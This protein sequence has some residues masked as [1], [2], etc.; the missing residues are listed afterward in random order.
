[1]RRTRRKARALHP[2]RERPEHRRQRE[3]FFASLSDRSAKAQPVLL[4]LGPAVCLPVF[5][6][7]PALL[8]GAPNP[9]QIKVRMASERDRWSGS[10]LRHS[11]MSCCDSGWSRRLITGFGPT[12]GR[13]R[14]F[15]ITIFES[16]MRRVY[17]KTRTPRIQGNCRLRTPAACPPSPWECQLGRFC[18]RIKAMRPRANRPP[19]HWRKGVRTY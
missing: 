14:F 13:P 6:P 15:R 7:I 5:A 9:I 1:V 4:D 2:W 11:S 16:D 12:R 10:P 18:C 17:N 19:Q 3:S 8:I